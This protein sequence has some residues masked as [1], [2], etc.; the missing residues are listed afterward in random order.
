MGN[1][2]RV[3]GIAR[4]FS[5]E[6]NRCLKHSIQLLLGLVAGR[7]EEVHPTN[8]PCV[9]LDQ[10]F[11]PTSCLSFPVFGEGDQGRNGPLRLCGSILSE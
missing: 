10:A 8:I 1:I 6:T 2:E 3:A 5:L 9:T 11:V 7:V 4:P